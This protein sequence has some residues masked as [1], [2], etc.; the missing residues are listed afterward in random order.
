MGLGWLRKDFRLILLSSNDILRQVKQKNGRGDA[1]VSEPLT[2]D[3]T[4]QIQWKMQRK[5]RV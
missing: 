2:I 5:K 3:I 1:R 4:H